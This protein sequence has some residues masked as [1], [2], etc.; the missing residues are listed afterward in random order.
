LN[1]KLLVC[2]YNVGG[3][4][5]CITLDAKGNVVSTQAGIPGLSDFSSP[6]DLVQDPS[7]G[8][9]YISEY[10]AQRITLARPQ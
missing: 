8:F 2:R 9:I 6:L 3:D 7:T 4:I 5:I 1:G 10:G